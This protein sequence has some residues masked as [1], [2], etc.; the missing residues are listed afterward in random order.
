MVS[1]E[2]SANTHL[3]IPFWRSELEM[4]T[5]RVICDLLEFSFQLGHAGIVESSEKL[6]K[7]NK[8]VRDYPDQVLSF[9][10][11]DIECGAVVGPFKIH[12]LQQSPFNIS[13]QHS[14]KVRYG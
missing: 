5:Y 4:Y 8:E 1:C 7:N 6:P 9:V 14:S 3:N 10:T 13:T 11:K 2:I 12:L